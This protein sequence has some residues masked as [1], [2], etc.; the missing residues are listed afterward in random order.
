MSKKE[1]KLED[2][3]HRM[4]SETGA[5]RDRQPGKG[6]FDLISPFALMRLAQVYEKGAAKFA[7]R[8]WES[9]LPYSWLIDSALRHLTQYLMGKD[10]E[11][12]L[13]QAAFNIFALMHFEDAMPGRFDDLPHY[14]SRMSPYSDLKERL[15]KLIKEKYPNR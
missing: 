8:N 3:G 12:H 15:E 11:D 14:T 4:K 2:T 9:G 5:M 1:F 6:R 13:A 10:D 7:D